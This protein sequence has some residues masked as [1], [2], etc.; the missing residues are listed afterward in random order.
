M[1]RTKISTILE[2]TLECKAAKKV[3]IQNRHNMSDCHECSE[4][5]YIRKKDRYCVQEGPGGGKNIWDL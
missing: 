4:K 2:L 3:V 1:N 5:I